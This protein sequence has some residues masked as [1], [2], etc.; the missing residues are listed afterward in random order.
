MFDIK[1]GSC[2]DIIDRNISARNFGLA[3]GVNK[4]ELQPLN[5][6]FSADMGIQNLLITYL[7]Q[8]KSKLYPVNN[9]DCSTGNKD[10]RISYMPIQ[11]GRN[12][13]NKTV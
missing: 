2:L 8:K 3:M 9:V 11:K 5:N 12:S 1:R 4:G 7:L 13:L 6:L 10:L